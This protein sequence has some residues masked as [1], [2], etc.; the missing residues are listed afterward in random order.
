MDLHEGLVLEPLESSV[1]D[2]STQWPEFS[3]KNIKV[4]SEATGGFV[5]LLTAHQGF[6]IRVEGILEEVD[7]AHLALGTTYSFNPIS[8][9]LILPAS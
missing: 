6:P 9:L 1:R 4:L 3:L 2:D 5:S 8:L 7:P